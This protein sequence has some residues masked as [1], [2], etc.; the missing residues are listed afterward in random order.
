MVALQHDDLLVESVNEELLVFN[1]RRSEATALNRSAALV[2][3]LCDGT[4]SVAQMRNALEAAGLGPSSDDAV[5]LALSELADADLVEL[6]VTPPKYQGRRELIKQF[7]VGAAALAALPVVETI[8]APSASVQGSFPAPSGSPTPAP[9][10]GSGGG[11]LAPTTAPTSAPTTVP[12]NAPTSAPT[13]APTTVPTQA[14][15]TIAPTRAPATFAPT[16][17]PTPAPSKFVPTQAPTP[18]QTQ[19]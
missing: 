4:N 5:W 10:V 18:S 12:T 13:T 6:L 11:T 15:G 3:E 16:T 2:F 7:G 17:M 1:P 9:S 8:R 19:I 14:P